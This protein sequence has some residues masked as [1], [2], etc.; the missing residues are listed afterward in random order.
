MQQITLSESSADL[1]RI[2]FAC[3][4]A[5]DR[6]ETQEIDLGDINTSDTFTLTFEG[7]TTAGITYAADMTTAITNALEALSNVAPGEATVVKGSG[8]VYEVTFSGQWAAIDVDLMTINSPT[9]FTP[10][11]VTEVE[12]GG[13]DG[14]PARGLTFAAA[15]IQISRNGTAVANS[16]GTVTELGNGLYYYEAT[17]GEVGTQGFLSLAVVKEDVAVVFPTVQVVASS[18]TLGAPVIRSGT[19]QAGTSGSITLD[20][21]ASGT[22]NFYVPSL[23]YIR[24]NTGAG[25]CRLIYAY[26]GSTKVASIEPNWVETPDSTSVFDI[27]PVEPLIVDLLRVNHETVDTFG[28]VSTELEV[29]TAVQELILD[30]AIPFSGADIAAI[31]GRLPAAL[32]SGKMSADVSSLAGDTTA[33]TRLKAHV[34]GVLRVVVDA[35]STTSLVVLEALTGV[36]GGVPNATADFYNGRTLVFTSGALAGQAKR[37]LDYSGVSKTL[38]V[39]PLTDAPAEGDT[40]VIV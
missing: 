12:H 2:L 22:S 31:E 1:R 27:L 40:G 37:I 16:A 7:Q 28:E 11:D 4:L 39:Q 29:A 10:G 24:T 9:T 19:A 17:A 5:A 25:Q 38:T 15:D 13:V 20:T 21:S 33:A 3:E 14:A 34:E 35:G 32:V 18:S 23:V 30:D 26:N 8:Q 36:E 6:N